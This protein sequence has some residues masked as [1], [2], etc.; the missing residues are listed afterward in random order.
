MKT[1]RMSWYWEMLQAKKSFERVSLSVEVGYQFN[2][3]GVA[4]L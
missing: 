2:S 4:Y 3:P 1:M